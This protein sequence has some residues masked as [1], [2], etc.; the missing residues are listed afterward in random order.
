MK[1]GWH[2]KVGA[3]IS[4][5]VPFIGWLFIY[6]IT[7]MGAVRKDGAEIAR[8]WSL[9]ECITSSSGVLSR[10]HPRFNQCSGDG[11]AI[12]RGHPPTMGSNLRPLA[13][14]QDAT[15]LDHRRSL[16]H[17]F[18]SYLFDTVALFCLDFEYLKQDHV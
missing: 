17:T 3:L 12:L 8:G 1:Q 4:S 13:R 14:V 18:G 7:H 15:P 16:A 2:T 6:P 9:P 5:V 11:S 10:P